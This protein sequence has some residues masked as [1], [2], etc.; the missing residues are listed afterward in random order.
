M[1][2]ESETLG[3][4]TAIPSVSLSF[5]ELDI[6]W[7]YGSSSSSSSVDWRVGPV[8]LA[9]KSWAKDNAI[10]D[11]FNGALSSYAVELMVVFYLQNCSP[12]V[13]PC[14]QKTDYQY[15]SPIDDI[16]SYEYLPDLSQLK[17]FESQNKQSLA[18]LYV[19]FFDY[20]M[21]VFDWNR[22][23][24]SVRLGRPLAKM[25]YEHYYGDPNQWEFI[26][27]EEPFILTNVGRTVYDVNAYNKI[28]RKWN[29][30]CERYK[31][32]MTL[33]CLRSR[34]CCCHE[35]RHEDRHEDED[36]WLNER[37][38]HP[39]SVDFINSYN[40]LPKKASLYSVSYNSMPISRQYLKSINY[41][42]K[43]KT[44]SKIVAII[45][46]IAPKCLKTEEIGIH[47]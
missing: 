16:M 47:C 14:L 33:K 12:P 37:S 11:S 28:V 32:A 26:C 15:F 18:E 45:N 46:T 10:I 9:I 27:I 17:P 41:F 20:Y 35:D 31:R 1:T 40:L 19:G 13:L 34:E 38:V 3:Y 36:E 4:C 29:H 22:Y 44:K 24:I 5:H 8:C 6:K 42:T 21:N 25:E 2:P 7:T 39:S 30:W 23:V 43:T